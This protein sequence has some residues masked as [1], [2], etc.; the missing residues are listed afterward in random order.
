MQ[1]LRANLKR[2]RDWF[3]DASLPLFAERGWDPAGGF[4]ESLD[5][6]GA[7]V[8]D[9]PRR[10]RVQA[11]QVHVFATAALLRR[12]PRAAD[13]ARRGFDHL[14]NHA[15]TGDGRR[16]CAHLLSP[17]GN[18][19]DAKRDHYDQAFL[20]LA[21]ASME[22][23]FA[24]DR[25]H[26]IA[27]R[28][29]AFLENELASPAGGFFEDDR[30]SAPRRQNPHMHL[31][32]AFLALHRTSCRTPMRETGDAP[33]GMSSGAEHSLRSPALRS[34]RGVGGEGLKVAASG[35]GPS[36]LTPLPRNRSA[37]DADSLAGARGTDRMRDKSVRPF[38]ESQESAKGPHLTRAAAIFDLFEQRFFP[39]D[40]DVL[41]EFFAE[42]LR[43]P[44]SGKGN[45]AEPG[46]M[47]EW[48]WL[49]ERHDGI[50]E[51][52]RAALQRRLFAGALRL[53]ED[54]SG[55]LVDRVR[56]GEKPAGARRLWPQTEYLK[57]ALIMARKGEKEAAQRA[58]RLL[59]GLFAT[60]LHHKVSGLWCDR[61]DGAGYPA[62]KSVPASILYHLMEAAL[63]AEKHI[64]ES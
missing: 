42:D 57:A 56:R 50:H 63:E 18:I 11:R 48:V 40:A 15:C 2:F 36:P 14:L 45:V 54:A 12:H 62:A 44:D 32:E 23:A 21:C 27:A 34:G 60:Y 53:G 46:H 52:K 41:R 37:S 38:Q 17:D 61:Y 6:D 7:P 25:S 10:V 43:T 9:E 1:R 59:D 55:F 13:L 3:W 58:E 29:V 39:P 33:F 8:L 64:K 49:L 30:G 26:A 35:A 24:D 28:V 4:Y 20:L 51:E 5:F 22:A 19:L 47:M 16:G 31:F